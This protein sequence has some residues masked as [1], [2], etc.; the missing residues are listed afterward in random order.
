MACGYGKVACAARV[1]IHPQQPL[2]LLWRW[3]QGPAAPEEAT[4]NRFT[5][6]RWR[7]S[8]IETFGAQPALCPASTDVGLKAAQPHSYPLFRQGNCGKAAS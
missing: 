4:R 5:S 6:K 3:T 1:A 2:D 8:P 7:L